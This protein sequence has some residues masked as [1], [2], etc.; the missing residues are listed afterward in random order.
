MFLGKEARAEPAGAFLRDN[1]VDAGE[2]ISLLH[3]ALV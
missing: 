1:E 3:D 2:V